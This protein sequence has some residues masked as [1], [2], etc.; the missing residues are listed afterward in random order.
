[1]LVIRYR[2][3]T[4]RIRRWRYEPDDDYEPAGDELAFG[5]DE[6]DHRDL[7][8]KRVDVDAE[9]PRLVDDP[10]ADGDGGD[11]TV[12]PRL[13]AAFRD[14]RDERDIQAQLDALFE[15]AADE[16]P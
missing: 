16:P 8:A 7:D 2:P 13:A 1:M 15:M 12:P 14:A 6:V 11:S 5:D 4:G 9:P 10:D 3:E